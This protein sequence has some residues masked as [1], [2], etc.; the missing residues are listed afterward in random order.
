MNIV[1]AVLPA[2]FDAE[3]KVAQALRLLGTG[4]AFASLITASVAVSQQVPAASS[5]TNSAGKIKRAQTPEEKAI[6]VVGGKSEFS[7]VSREIGELN[8]Q[9]LPPQPPPDDAARR[10]RA[11]AEMLN[12]Q[13]LPPK[14]APSEKRLTKGSL[15]AP[16]SRKSEK[17]RPPAATQTGSLQEPQ[18]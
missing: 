2:Q 18:P 15:S 14:A 7:G 11:E 3:R 13:P 9:P 6:I 1:V 5:P 8:P 17:A 10:H 12:P 16:A 4:I